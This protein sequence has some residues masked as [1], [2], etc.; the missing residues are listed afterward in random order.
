MMEE[1][2]IQINCG[3]TINVDVNLKNIMHVKITISGILLHGVVK[4]GNISQVL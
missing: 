3:I 2:L 4:M 1:N